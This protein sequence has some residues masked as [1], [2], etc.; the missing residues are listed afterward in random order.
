MAQLGGGIAVQDRMAFQ[1]K[2]FVERYGYAAARRA[3]PIR[4]MLAAGIPVGAGTDA[5]RVS[6]YN[7]WPSLAW[8]ITGKTIGGAPLCQDDGGLDRERALRLWTRANTWFCSD[9]GTRGVIAP[10]YHGNLAVLSDDYFMVDESKIDRIES[11]LTV[12]GGQIVH[13]AQEFSPMAPPLPPAMPDWSPVRTFG[14]YGGLAATAPAVVR[15]T[16][17]ARG[18]HRSARARVV[19]APSQDRAFWGALGCSCWAF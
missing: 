11:V 16:T 14:G 6:S 5:T 10:G 1:G 2:Y 18:V 9:E 19:S 3:P 8:L 12:V 13:G 15:G 4:E 17:A 7:P